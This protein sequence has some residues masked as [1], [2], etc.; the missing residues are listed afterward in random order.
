MRVEEEVVVLD[1]GAISTQVS[2][3]ES[4]RREVE[5][6]GEWPVREGRPE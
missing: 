4:Q 2:A 1:K 5:R 3:A 6:V